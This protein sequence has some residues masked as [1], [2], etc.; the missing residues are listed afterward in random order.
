MDDSSDDIVILDSDSK[1]VKAMRTPERRKKPAKTIELVK[2]EKPDVDPAAVVTPG[3]VPPDSPKTVV[4]DACNTGM[5]DAVRRP[6]SRPQ[7]RC[8]MRNSTQT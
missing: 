4:L 6:P 1:E 7:S 5:G 2:K 8:L 3:A